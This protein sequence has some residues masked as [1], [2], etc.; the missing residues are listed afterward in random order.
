M[1]F[2]DVV[3]TKTLTIVC[4]PDSKKLPNEDNQNRA[5]VSYN[6]A[7]LAFES[8][9]PREIIPQHLGYSICESEKHPLHPVRNKRYK[10]K[11][12]KL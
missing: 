5:D 6:L 8:L 7:F 9:E 4:G 2:V 11:L 10:R 1:S 12:K 3:Y